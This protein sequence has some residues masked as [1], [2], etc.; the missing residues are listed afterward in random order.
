[1]KPFYLLL[2]LLIS[3]A[4]ATAQTQAVGIK[5][6]LANYQG[7]LV[8]KHVNISES[9][10]AAGVFFRRNL[11]DLFAV[12][13]AADLATISGSDLNYPDRKGR[14]ISFSANIFAASINGQW[15]I[16]GGKRFDKNGEFKP[17]FSPVIYS[18]LGA[19][20]FSPEVSG[21]AD[22]NLDAPELAKAGQQY[23]FFVP[24]GMGCHY[25]LNPKFTIGLE[26]T[27]HLPFTDYLDGVSESGRMGNNDWFGLVTF[28]IQ[29]WIDEPRKMKRPASDK[30]VEK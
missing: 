7:D 27:T 6:G 26:A 21:M 12:R 14:G 4:T 24:F 1:M 9:H 29:Y 3:A 13:I 5:L 17:R 22:F 2:A 23:Q 19:V 28:S 20:L 8:K 30:T 16:L 18:G 15:N 11:N 25:E 10:L